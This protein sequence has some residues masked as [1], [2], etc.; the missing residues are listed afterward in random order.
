MA[1]IPQHDEYLQELTCLE[2]MVYASKLKNH[3]A[4]IDDTLLTLNK[5]IIGY[6]Y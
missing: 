5:E 1:Y 4:S 2:I 6:F 3:T